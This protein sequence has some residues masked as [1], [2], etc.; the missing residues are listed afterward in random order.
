M[1][2]LVEATYAVEF[3]HVVH[4]PLDAKLM[5]LPPEFPWHAGAQLFLE[6]NMPVVSGAVMDA[7]HK[8]I[9]A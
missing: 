3:G 8:G 9:R 2:Q 5:E 6:R 7:T 4:P 1:Y